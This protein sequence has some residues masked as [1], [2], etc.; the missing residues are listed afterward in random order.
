MLSTTLKNTGQGSRHG[1]V[2][3]GFCIVTS[4]HPSPGSFIMG[5]KHFNET[6]GQSSEKL[7]Y[8]WKC[9]ISRCYNNKDKGYLRYGGRGIRVYKPW[10]NNPKLFINYVKKLHGY[11]DKIKMTLDRKNNDGNYVPSNLRWTDYHTQTANRGINKNNTSGYK[12]VTF[13]KH[14]NKWQ[15]HIT[16]NWDPI[17]LGLYDSPYEASIARKN[18]ILSN[19]LDEYGS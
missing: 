12:G 11:S 13:N 4:E 15:S 7:Y 5:K 16:V 17:Y 3:G 1:N 2:S 6:H 8:I 19:K 9:I 10:I 14:A 18:Y